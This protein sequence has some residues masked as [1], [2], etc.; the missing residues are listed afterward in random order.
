M[1]TKHHK[2]F[3][4]CITWRCFNSLWKTKQMRKEKWW[5]HEL[6]K[7]ISLLGYPRGAG[8]E[9][10][11][12][13]LPFL[14]TTNGRA[15]RSWNSTKFTCLS[16]SW[17]PRMAGPERYPNHS[18]VESS[19]SSFWSNWILDL[20]VLGPIPLLQ[21]NWSTN[22]MVWETWLSRLRDSLHPSNAW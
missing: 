9:G 13:I 17:M 7:M 3:S 5:Y 21:P 6:Q 1:S 20:L 16:P 18:L 2:T 4:T 8:P 22:S 15:R 11:W 12:N 19:S 10:L 14:D